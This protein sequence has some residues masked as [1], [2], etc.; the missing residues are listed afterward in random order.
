MDYACGDYVDQETGKMKR[1]IHI[2]VFT[3]QTFCGYTTSEVGTI[4]LRHFQ[5]QKDHISSLTMC[6]SC[7][8]MAED[9]GLGPSPVPPQA[10]TDPSLIRA[11]GISTGSGTPPLID[12]E[13][14][15]PFWM[16]NA[17]RKEPPND[18]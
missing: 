15:L 1:E 12:P 5:E 9:T 17:R 8:S 10:V 7:V 18:L 16:Q 11:S 2:R 14:R 6:R 3:G 4:S 13:T